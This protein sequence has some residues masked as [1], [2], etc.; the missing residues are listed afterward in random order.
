MILRIP[1]LVLTLGVCFAGSGHPQS[2]RRASA[3]IKEKTMRVYSLRVPGQWGADLSP[4]GR[5][6]AVAVL[7]KVVAP[8]T[9][10]EEAFVDVEVWDF[11]AN[12]R[13]AQRTLEHRPASAPV[14]AE[15]GQVRYS[16]D[17]RVLLVYDGELLSVLQADTLEEITRIDLGL[18]AWPRDSQ[19][20]DLAMPRQAARE[21]AVLLSWGGGRGGAVRLYDLQTGA[22]GRQW[23]FDHGYPEL[24]ARVA[25]K[26]DGR[27]LAV[28]LLPVV[29][30][31]QLPKGEKTL[32]VMDAE[33]GKILARIN[34]GYL[35]GPVC[36][37]ADDKLVTATAEPAWA[38]VL[39]THKIK[40]WNATTGHLLREI[41]SPLSGVRESLVLSAD[42]KRLLG[43][44]GSEKATLNLDATDP[45]EILEQKFRLWDLP[46]GRMVATS[47]KILPPADKRAQLRLSA[48]GDLVLVF[49]SSADKPL[50]VYEID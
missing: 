2:A 48:K 37:T 1:A 40:I 47:P 36:F 41:E 46:T 16:G 42:G 14:T 23:E 34:T 44:V 18:P 33:S 49:W 35:A 6:V 28:S 21:V 38:L 17:G 25:W 10:K 20:V 12:K 15:W 43:Y 11:R 9:N 50:L 29:P 32:Q 24:G 5:W 22:L 3:P 19:V 13:M 30:G 45:T 27:K 39:G 8:E 26:P 7:R 4:D 31:V